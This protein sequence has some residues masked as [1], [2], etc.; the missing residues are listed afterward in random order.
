VFSGVV[1]VTEGVIFSVVFAVELFV[2]VDVTTEAGVS[3]GVTVET[4]VSAGV[5]AAD[6]F[7]VFDVLLAHPAAKT[8]AIRIR[9]NAIAFK[10]LLILIP[11]KFSS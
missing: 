2:S 1:T 9:S 6:E 8:T 3:V 10:I 7:A 4:G 11:L 5:T